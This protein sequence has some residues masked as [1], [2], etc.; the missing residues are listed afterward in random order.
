[1]NE[2]GESLL[3]MVNT[4]D[5]EVYVSGP[6]TKWVSGESMPHSPIAAHPKLLRRFHPPMSLHS[7]KQG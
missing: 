3:K 6:I 1:M 5:E 2:G 4:F 7:R